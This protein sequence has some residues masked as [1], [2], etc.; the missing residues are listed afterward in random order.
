MEIVGVDGARGI[1]RLSAQ[2]NPVAGM[3]D[4]PPLLG[5]DGQIDIGRLGHRKAAE[6]GVSVLASAENFDVGEVRTVPQA[7]KVTEKIDLAVGVRP[8]R[9]LIDLLEQNEVRLVPRDDLRDSQ[10][11]VSSVDTPDAFVDVVGDDSKAHEYVSTRS[12]HIIIARGCDT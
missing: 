11:V 1:S 7:E 12:K 10:R 9:V 8:A 5:R 6:H 4:A 2:A 3:K